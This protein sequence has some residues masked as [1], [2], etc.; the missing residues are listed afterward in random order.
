MLKRVTLPIL[1]ALG[2]VCTTAHAHNPGIYLTWNRD[3]SRVFYNRCAVCHR[4]DGSAFSLMTYPEVQPRLT[5]IKNAVLNRRMPPWGAVKGFGDFRNDQAL[6]QEEIELISDWIDADAPKGNNPNLLP[7]LPKFKKPP[8]FEKPKGS[9]DAT[10]ALTL[11]RPFILDGLYPEKLP[12]GKAPR[13]VAEFP[14][15]RIE[16]LLWLYEYNDSLPHPFL[17]RN[18]LELPA[19]TKIRGIPSDARVVLLLGKKSSAKARP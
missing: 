5:E 8:P 14:D 6:T 17:F 2:T 12:D 9:L 1:L 4:P 18:P 3:I 7:A 11:D 19:G 15:S 13:I 16:P 10:G